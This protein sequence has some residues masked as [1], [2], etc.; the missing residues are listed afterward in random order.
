MA[1]MHLELVCQLPINL[2]RRRRRSRRR[3]VEKVRE[4]SDVVA[5]CPG[6]V[7]VV[8]VHPDDPEG[9]CVWS[10]QPTTAG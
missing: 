3:S 8:S 7:C 5:G 10:Y 9:P 4:S 1:V 6:G 2:I